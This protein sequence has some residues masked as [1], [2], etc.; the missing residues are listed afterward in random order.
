MLSVII[1]GKTYELIFLVVPKLTVDII[2]GCESFASWNAKVDFENSR[3]SIV[4]KGNVLNIPFLREDEIVDMV[5]VENKSRYLLCR[6][7]GNSQ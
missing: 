2:I 6:I 4:D 7:Y 3:L 5:N 1:N